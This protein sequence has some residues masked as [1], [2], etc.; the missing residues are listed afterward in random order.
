MDLCPRDRVSEEPRMEAPA[1]GVRRSPGRPCLEGL[2]APN[3]YSSKTLIGSVCIG[4]VTDEVS[5][6]GSL[7]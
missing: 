5:N 7:N 4:L 3:I 1:S 2:P 6:R